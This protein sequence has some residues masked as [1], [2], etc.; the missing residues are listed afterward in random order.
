MNSKRTRKAWMNLDFEI[1]S[2]I[3]ALFDNLFQS[4]IKKI[5]DVCMVDF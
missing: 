2:Q 4:Q 1:E 3:L 5:L